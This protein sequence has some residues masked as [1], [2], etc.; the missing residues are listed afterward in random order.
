ML[1][2]LGSYDFIRPHIRLQIQQIPQ[3]EL[4]SDWYD[5]TLQVKERK[6]TLYAWETSSSENEH[7]WTVFGLAPYTKY[8]FR[9]VI[10]MVG[11]QL[12]TEDYLDVQDTE[13]VSSIVTQPSLTVRTELSKVEGPSKPTI[14]SVHQVRIYFAWPYCIIC[15]LYT[16]PS[17]RDQRGSRMPSSA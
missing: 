16:S 14:I 6:S 8:K 10:H 15:L 11:S 12:P 17:P 5:V 2:F 7:H 13:S 4:E 3:N 1:S 9:V